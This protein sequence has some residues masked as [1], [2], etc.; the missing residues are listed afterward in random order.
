[1]HSQ[2]KFLTIPILIMFATIGISVF[3]GAY[4]LDPLHWAL[5]FS[6]AQDLVAHKKPYEEIFIQYGILTT[7]IHSLAFII[8][9]SLIS[10]IFITALFYFIGIF[11]LFKISIK[12]LPD[13]DNS[14]KLILII[15]LFHPIVIYPWSNYIAFPFLLG[16]LYLLIFSKAKL[17]LLS[18]GIL[19]GLSALA[20]ENLF[21]TIIPGIIS[22]QLMSWYCGQ[23]KIFSTLEKTLII[24][25]GA[26]IPVSIFIFWLIYSDLFHY[27]LLFSI[28]LPKLYS[29][30]FF[31]HMRGLNILGP[32]YKA[33]YSGVINLDFRWILV[34]I[35]LIVNI[36]FCI[37]FIFKSKKVTPNLVKLSAFSLLLFSSALHSPEIFRIATGSIVGLIPVFYF[38]TKKNS[39]NLFF[40][41]FC[42][43]LSITFIWRN[44][45]LMY[46]PTLESIFNSQKVFISE[47]FEGQRWNIKKINYY[48]EI[49]RSF[50]EIKSLKNCQINYQYNDTGDGFI[51]VLSPFVQRQM[52]P[53][54]LNPEFSALRPD[55]QL[56]LA[57]NGLIDTLFIMVAPPN[58]RPLILK[59][60]P[61]NYYLYKTIL[62][63]D[64]YYLPGGQEMLFIL[65]KACEI[66][67]Q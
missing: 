11:I 67:A 56:S 26:L 49:L 52:A 1:M 58:D 15:F 32:L 41:F 54:Q 12:I 46:F 33:V 4:H 25:C 50:G 59:K 30:T 48:D 9:S 3:R 2:I 45:S 36:Y 35:I 61:N 44:S 28:E 17:D 55:L 18:S 29:Q 21:I 62:I 7:L 65:P 40:W 23:E 66:K 16:G 27:W 53:W 34:I 51:K 22:I 8:K 42:L 63:P 10:I 39:L 13:F 60:I 38:L 24:I 57:D 64:I 31:P 43:V 5:M 20:R 14:I 6:N 19:F 37:L 47:Y